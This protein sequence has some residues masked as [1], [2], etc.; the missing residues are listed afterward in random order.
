MQNVAS[1]VSRILGHGVKCH[2]SGIFLVGLN[3]PGWIDSSCWGGTFV[4]RSQKMCTLFWRW[5]SEICD[6][7]NAFLLLMILGKEWPFQI[8]SFFLIAASPSPSTQPWPSFWVGSATGSFLQICIYLIFK[9]LLKWFVQLLT[10]WLGGFLTLVSCYFIMHCK[11]FC[12]REESLVGSMDCINELCFPA[13]PC[14]MIDVH[15]YFSFTCPVLYLCCC[16]LTHSYLLL[17]ICIPR[18]R[19][20]W[21]SS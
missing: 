10:M 5:S 17:F 20:S 18:K 4:W 6:Y 14:L 7:R 21:S 13:N 9:C 19:S 1:E 11:P 16:F 3:L 8:P 2:F 15:M 12:M